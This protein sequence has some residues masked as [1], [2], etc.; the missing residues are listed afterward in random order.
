MLI[1]FQ[2][3]GVAEREIEEGIVE[4]VTLKTRETGVVG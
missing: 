3:F 4:R 2:S 1:G